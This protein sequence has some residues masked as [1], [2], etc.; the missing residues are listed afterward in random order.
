MKPEETRPDPMDWAALYAAG[1]IPA[2]ERSKFENSAKNPSDDAKWAAVHRFDPVVEQLADSTSPVEPP[3]RIRA[4]LLERIAREGM[5]VSERGTPS[6]QV[7]KDWAPLPAMND[8]FIRRSGE[9]GWEE[10]GVAGVRVRQLFV[11]RPHNRITMLV[12]MDAGASY[13]KH[14]HD[15]AEECLV[16][17]GDLWMGDTVLRKGDYQRAPA[18]SLHGVQRTEAGCLLLIT[19]SLSDELV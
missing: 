12:Q 3:A 19:S 10:T 4:E 7:W 9:G 8:L 11:D 1:A 16:L 14:L 17:E 18:G 2:R 13:P 6:P 15:D 5:P